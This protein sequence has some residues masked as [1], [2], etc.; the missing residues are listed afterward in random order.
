MT[1]KRAI[2]SLFTEQ[3]GEINI[4]SYPI[5]TA[6]RIICIRHITRS[7]FRKIGLVHNLKVKGR[8]KQ[9]MEINVSVVILII[10]LRTVNKWR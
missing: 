8:I 7:D 3:K 4:R 6:V 9:S 2:V 1:R 10:R 5:L